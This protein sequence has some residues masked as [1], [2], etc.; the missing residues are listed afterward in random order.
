MAKRLYSFYRSHRRVGFDGSHPDTGEV[1]PSM[2]KQSFKAECDINNII[3]SFKQT[4]MVQHIN[5]RAAAGAFLDLPEGIDLQEALNTVAVAEA[6]F[7]SLPAKIRD[8]FGNDPEQFLNFI[9]DPKNE[10]EARELGLL[11]PLPPEPAVVS[12][13]K[14]A[15]PAPPPDDK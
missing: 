9:H 13:G 6:A 1:M 14:D 3:K 7:M 11:N 2:T 8:R 5:E 10:A 15:P 4:G 12:P